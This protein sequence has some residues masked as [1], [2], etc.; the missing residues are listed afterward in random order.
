MRHLLLLSLLALLLPA[1]ARA[2]A[3]PQLQVV[4]DP[5][6]VPFEMFDRER[7]EMVGF[8]IDILREVAQRAGFRYRLRTMDFN[9]IIPALQSGS[10][11]LAL[12]GITITE[13]RSRIVDF[14]DP[15]YDSGLR[16]LVRAG[17]EAI[18]SL[19]DLRGR[20]VATKIGSTS[21]DLL[22]E[23]LGES[24]R[25]TPYP[26]STDM[27]M[28]L[29]SGGVDAVFYDAPNIA[30]F[31]RTRGAGRVQ[32]VGPR[33][34]GQQYGI[35]LVK[36]SPWRERVNAALAAM[37]QDGTYDQLHEKWFGATP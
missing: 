21:H 12:A 11:D 26:G 34:A 2:E 1:A 3:L 4:T 33:Y 13:A 16:L 28:A 17:E 8:D 19:E 29:L 37:R 10:A 27:Y 5:S 22:R 24:A 25:I 7:G 20:R 14:S 9:G 18:G 23:R 35:A 31:A 15:Y 36:G 32:P 6:F 30:Y